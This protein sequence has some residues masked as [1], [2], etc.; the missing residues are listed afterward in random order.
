VN[1]PTQKL[2]HQPFFESL[3]GS[4]ELLLFADSFIPSG[5]DLGYFLLFF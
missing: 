5:E 2:L 3:F 1:L 4:D